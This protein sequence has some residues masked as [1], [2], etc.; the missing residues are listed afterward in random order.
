MRRATIV[1]TLTAA[2]APGA[3][4]ALPAAVEWL[5]IR[6]DLTGELDPEALRRRFRGSLLYTLRSAAEG[7]SFAGPISVRRERL[8]RAA[9]SYDRVDLEAD[10]DLAPELLAGIPPERFGLPRLEAP[11]VSL[12]RALGRGFRPRQRPPQAAPEAEAR[13][14]SPRRPNRASETCQL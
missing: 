8:R 2:P 1:A 5:E 4:E 11:E 6:A 13:D 12:G 10:R 9:E 7:G 14:A 3:L